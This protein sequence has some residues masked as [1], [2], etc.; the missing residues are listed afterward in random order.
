VAVAYFDSS[1][2][3]KLCVY[4]AESEL[5]VELW[6]RCDVAVSSRLCF[7]EV[8]AALAAARR[9][10]RASDRELAQAD[11]LW[12]ERWDEISVVEM[13]AEVAD[14]AGELAGKHAL[15]GADAVHLASA[16]ALAESGV[17]FVAWDHRLRAGAHAEGLNVVPAL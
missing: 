2:L 15:S 13:T 7:P 1:A 5:V 9:T 6:S 10:G 11:R 14:V 3:V 8:M 4:E 12:A 17:L 16:G